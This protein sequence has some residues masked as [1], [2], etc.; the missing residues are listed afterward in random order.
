MSILAIDQGTSSTKAFLLRETGELLALGSLSHRQDYPAPDRVEQD[1][2]ELAGNVETL[3]RSALQRHP[4]IVGIALA[5]QGETVVAFDRESGRALHPAIVWQDARTS[6][7]LA[8]FSDAMRD[9]VHESAGLP[10][11]PYFSAAKLAW[12]LTQVE[13]VA[14]AAKAGR[15]GLATSDAFLLHRLTGSYLTDAATASRTS[16]MH[17]AGREWDGAL[18]SL[19]GVPAELLPPIRPCCGQFGEVRAG[20]RTVPVVAS[21]VDQQAALFGHG[22]REPGE[23]KITF[24]TGTFALAVTGERPVVDK[25]GLVPTLAWWLDPQSPPVYALDG[26]DYTASSALDWAIGIGLAQRAEE[27]LVMP[28]PSMLENGLIFVPALAGLAAPHWD[29]QAA[30]LFAGL[31]QSTTKAELR[32]AVLE[33]VALRAAEIVE[34]LCGPDPR[35]ISVDGGM[36]RNEGFLGFLADALGRPVVLRDS[37]D[38]TALGVAEIG[39]LALG[40]PVPPRSA[41]ART[42]T[43]SP[44][45]A[46]VLAARS[47]FAEAVAAS[48]SLAA[49][50]RADQAP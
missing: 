47:R 29:R 44:R 8:T 34:L 3:V 9:L 1:A 33:G 42:I 23:A 31:R 38:L 2:E 16:L 50:R 19:F 20:G 43:P 21:V 28:G 14:E 24:G 5:N 7:H 27:F 17:L 15:L 25:D 40:R 4:E 32:Q 18:C 11:D 26:G 48:R 36:T 10:L 46:L 6:A 30:G 41:A 12:L 39:F 13:A 35:P 37:P 49:G 45:S 22:C